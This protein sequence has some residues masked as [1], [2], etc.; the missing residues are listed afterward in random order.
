MTITTISLIL[1]ATCAQPIG[2]YETAQRQKPND[3][4]APEATSL[5]GRPLYANPPEAQRDRLESDLRRAREMMRDRPNDPEAIIWVGRRLGYLWRMT[6]AVEVYTRGIEKHRKYAPLYRHRGH[7]YITLRQF[8]RA[9]ADLESAS[10]LITGQEDVIEQDGAPNARNIPLTTLHF[11]V[12]YHL[13]VARYLKGDFSGALDAFEKCMQCRGKYDDNLV[14]VT[15]WMYMAMRRLNRDADAEKLLEPITEE[16]EIIENHAYHKRLLMYKGL[17]RPE[18]LLDVRNASDLDLATMG[19]GVGN[20]HL[21]EGNRAKAVEIFEKVVAGG[22]WPAFGYI[23]SEADLAR[24]RR[25]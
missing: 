25:R 12:W 23:A 24:L 3:L 22:Y 18:D 15:D 6:E 14:A 17:L 7:R 5:L 21:C 8:D 20:W 9:I 4:Q 16:M 2:Q 19:Y 13:G 1:A 10:R 11:N